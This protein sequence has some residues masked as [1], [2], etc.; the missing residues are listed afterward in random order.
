MTLQGNAHA[1]SVL[2]GVLADWF[3]AATG[4]WHV[5]GAFGLGGAGVTDDAN[6]AIGGVSVGGEVFGGYQWWLGP[7]WSLGISGLMTIAPRLNMTDSNA[8][9]TGYHMVPL[10]AG[11]QGLLLYY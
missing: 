1:T 5:G 9:D 4:G 3:P 6:R 7:S 10:S 2:L 8:N 11:L